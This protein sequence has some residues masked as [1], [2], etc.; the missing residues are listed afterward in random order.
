MRDGKHVVLYVDDDP[1][2]R[3]AVR[4]ILEAHG[5]EMDEAASAE[6]G[7]RVFKSTSP[8]FVLVD[9]MM[10]EI[11]AGTSLV[12]EMKAQGASIPIY[13]LSSV[14]E[15]LTMNTDYRELGLDGVLQK[16][17]EADR[18]LKVLRSKLEPA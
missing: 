16:P 12:R 15:N 5:Y 10:E 18:L 2:Y 11:D 7:M 6:E 8:D 1:D 4:S 9:L 3:M 13:M 17:V 14:G